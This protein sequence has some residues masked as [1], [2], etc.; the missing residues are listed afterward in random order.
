MDLKEFVREA[1]VQVTSGV[2]EAQ[3]QVREKGG[4]VNPSVVSSASGQPEA[5]HFGTLNSGQNVL[6]MEFDVAVTATDSTEGGAGAKLAVASVF[7]IQAGGK[8]TSGSESTSRIR[9]KVPFALPLDAESK[10]NYDAEK[11]RQDELIRQHNKG[12]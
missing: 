11:R 5:T 8:G 10:K 1:L 7:S 12:L 9:F 3:D 6:L 4:Y 2:R